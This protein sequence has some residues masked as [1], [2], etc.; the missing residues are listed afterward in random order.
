MGLSTLSQFFRRA[1]FEYKWC[2]LPRRC[3]ISNKLLWMRVA[4]RGTQ[5][6]TGPGTPVV[7]TNWFDPAEFLILKLKGY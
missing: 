5:V 4:V 6:I 1:I 3:A 7:I 2:L